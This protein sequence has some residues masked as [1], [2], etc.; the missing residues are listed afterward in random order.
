[1]RNVIRSAKASRRLAAVIAVTGSVGL[2]GTG[3]G[4]A[5]AEAR[6]CSGTKH[7]TIEANSF[8]SCAFARNIARSF[9]RAVSRGTIDPFTDDYA[10]GTAYS[11]AKDRSYR[12]R[13]YFRDSIGNTAEWRCSA[14]RGAKVL[15]TYY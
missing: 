5:S 1:M 2:L 6:S 15:L 9:Q 12:V 4:T 8:T 11:P 14:G 10:W 3:V 7:T 13:C